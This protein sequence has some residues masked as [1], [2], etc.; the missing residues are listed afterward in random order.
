MLQKDLYISKSDNIIMK[1]D[2]IRLE[3]KI[4]DL[5][6]RNP[7]EK[8]SINEIAKILSEHYSFV[9]K[10]TNKLIKDKIILKEKIGKSHICSL[11]IQNEKTIALII[12]SEIE[13]KEKFFNSNKEL[14]L[15]FDDFVKSVKSKISVES[16]ILFGSYAKGIQTQKSDIDLLIISDKK[17]KVDRCARDIYAKYGKEI[18]AVIMTSNDFR[19]QK[20]KP[21]IKEII[22]NHCIIVGTNKF[23]EMLFG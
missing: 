21:L 7:E 6:A 15:I 10:I 9:H 13:R 16:I 18:N 11:N 22:N 19:G 8:Y 3:L 5:L 12:L 14:K 2:K 23:I 17:N 4:V 1:N 20:N